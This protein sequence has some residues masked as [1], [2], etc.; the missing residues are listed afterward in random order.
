MTVERDQVLAAHFDAFHL[1]RDRSPLVSVL[2]AEAMGDG[3]PVEVAPYS[4]C[5][6]TV[7]G[8]LVAGLRVRP[9]GVVA[10]VG[11]GTGGAGLWLARALQADL[12]GVDVSPAAVRIAFTRRARFGMAGRARFTVGTLEATGL[13]EDS[14]D[15]VVCVDALA[16]AGDRVQALAEMRRIVRPGGRLVMTRAGTGGLRAVVVEQAAAAGLDVEDVQERPGEPEMWGR[17]YRLWRARAGELRETV[18]EDQA[19]GMLREAERMLPR[20][21]G[22]VALLVTLRRPGLPV[23]G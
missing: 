3:Y 6:W 12:V 15:G 5:D 8:A 21:E 19:A 10:D 7:L 23:A 22:R 14:V 2:Y 18:G 17:L 16:N 11:C 13:P 20:L 4:S 9:G 1:A